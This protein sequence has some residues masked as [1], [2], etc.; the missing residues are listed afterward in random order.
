M[1]TSPIEVRSCEAPH[2]ILGRP[3]RAVVT[4]D[5]G[6][7]GVAKSPAGHERAAWPGGDPAPAAAGWMALVPEAPDKGTL[8]SVR[9]HSGEARMGPR[10]QP[11]GHR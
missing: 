6:P 3:I 10:G 8:G 9:V 2:A 1:T 7:A 11:G 5:A 4:D